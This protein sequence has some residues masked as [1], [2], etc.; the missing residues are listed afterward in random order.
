MRKLITLS[1]VAGLSSFAFADGNSD[2]ATAKAKVHIVAP[3]KIVSDGEINFGQIVVDDITQDA[4]VTMTTKTSDNGGTSAKLEGWSKCAQYKK[5]NVAIRGAEFH[6]SHDVQTAINA[7]ASITIDPSVTLTGGIG[8]D[9]TLK[10][11]SDLPADQCAL[12]SIKGQKEIKDYVQFNHFG[13]GGT[14]TIPA[15]ALGYKEGTLTVK[16]EYI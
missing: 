3:V 12:A 8:S 11:N 16:V 10:T 7:N 4:S 15:G 1:L 2:S 14:L 13:V 9:V 5:N 6:Y